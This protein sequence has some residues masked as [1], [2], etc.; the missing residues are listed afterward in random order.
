MQINLFRDRFG[1]LAFET[2]RYINLLTPP[3][4]RWRV[5]R[6]LRTAA[7]RVGKSLPKKIVN[8]PP[9]FKIN[10]SMNEWIGSHIAF[11]RTYE[12]GL[13]KLL[14][15]VISEQAH[16]V[17]VGANIGFF[18]LLA[19]CKIS[20]KGRVSAI[21]A[22][23]LTAQQLR[24]NIELNGYSKKVDVYEVAAWSKQDTLRFN[25][26]PAGKS[27]E[28]SVREVED[29]SGSCQVTAAALDDIIPYIE[30][31]ITAIKFDVEGAELEAIKG[32]RKIIS[33]QHPVIF[34][35]LSNKYLGQLD[36]K[37]SDLINLLTD[38]YSYQIFL[39]DQQGNKTPLT[40]KHISKEMGDFQYNLIC[41]QQ[42][43]H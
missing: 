1:E 19:A 2:L 13:A 8:C 12:P 18:T 22:N 25:I 32:A 40:P 26:A 31:P 11:E 28:A 4:I 35:E 21:E 3:G 34:L 10:V 7:R 30:Y 17:D 20:E 39:Y 6:R 15:S 43:K 36:A 14:D 37:S 27:G 16:F 33:E 24:D 9:G 23:P 41:M 38:E 5:N 42:E 29:S